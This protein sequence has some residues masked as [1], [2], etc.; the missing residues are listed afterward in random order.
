MR[1]AGIITA[2]GGSKGLRGKNTIYLA[3]KPLIVHT[4]EAAL[5]SK[6]INRCIVSTEDPGIK[7][8][9][10][11]AGAEVLDRPADL[12]KDNSLSRDVVLHVLR[13]LERDGALPEYFIL[14]QPTSP[15][16]NSDHIDDCISFFMKNKAG[17]SISVCEPAHSPFK[18]FKMIGREMYPISDWADLDK[19]RQE[20]PVAYRPNGAMYLASSAEFMDRKTFFIRPVTP[21]VMGQRESVDIDNQEDLEMCEKIFEDINR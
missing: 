17:S 21:F 8:V 11:S 15:L 3:G 2:R 14:L 9:S 18:S 7:S 16:R 10:L 12:A 19:P 1:I 4:I 6:L 13:E 5:N 20:L